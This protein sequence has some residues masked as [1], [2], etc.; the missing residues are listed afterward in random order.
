MNIYRYE[1]GRVLRMGNIKDEYG[2]SDNNKEGEGK[3][4]TTTTPLTA[5]NATRNNKK[6]SATT[7]AAVKNNKKKSVGVGSIKHE[8]CRRWD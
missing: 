3:G 7:T 5:K 1:V 8:Q 6:K 4:G 2:D